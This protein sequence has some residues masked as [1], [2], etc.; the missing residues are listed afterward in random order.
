MSQWYHNMGLISCT[1][2]LK[3]QIVRDSLCR[4]VAHRSPAI[5]VKVV[6]KAVHRRSW[7]NF[8]LSCSQESLWSA[9]NENLR[10]LQSLKTLVEKTNHHHYKFMPKRLVWCHNCTLFQVEIFTSSVHPEPIV[11]GSFHKIHNGLGSIWPIIIGSFHCRT[12]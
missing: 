3:L 2:K 5:A 7:T 1:A 4:Q 11:I 6:K 12:S 8:I 10:P 9:N